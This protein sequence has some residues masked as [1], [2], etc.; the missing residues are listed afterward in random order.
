M[1]KG[2]E[3]TMEKTVKKKVH[4]ETTERYRFTTEDIQDLIMDKYALAG[5]IN[6]DWY[7]GQRVSLTVTV[8]KSEEE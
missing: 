1:G 8:K 4:I 3:S 6:F 5:D 2:K 7:I